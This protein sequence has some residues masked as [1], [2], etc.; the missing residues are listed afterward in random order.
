MDIVQSCWQ[1]ET[2]KPQSS[3]S[4][5]EATQTYPVPSSGIQLRGHEFGKATIVAKQ[6][7]EQQSSLG[8]CPITNTAETQH[9]A[10]ATS[11]DLLP[12]TAGSCPEPAP[13]C[14]NPAFT[15]QKYNHE[16]TSS[17]ALG[18]VF[19]TMWLAVSLATWAKGENKW[20]KLFK[21]YPWIIVFA[22]AFLTNYLTGHDQKEFKKKII[23]I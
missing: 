16:E 14:H 15:A 1:Q 11:L 5:G 8:S 9:S 4:H 19:W 6:Q 7:L 13:L 10:A 17:I 21:I 18:G 22:S 23:T 12:V 2:P 20:E 3:L